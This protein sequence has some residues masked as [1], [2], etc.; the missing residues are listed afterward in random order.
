MESNS[1]SVQYLLFHQFPRIK[2]S[3]HVGGCLTEITLVAASVGGNTG[4]HLTGNTQRNCGLLQ[5]IYVGSGSEPPFILI[6]VGR[7]IRLGK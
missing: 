7:G 1:Y 2:C 5:G 6:Q 3:L 4:A